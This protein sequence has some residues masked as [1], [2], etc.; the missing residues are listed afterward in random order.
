M[1][2]VATPLARA[3]PHVQPAISIG[4]ATSSGTLLLTYLFVRWDGVTA[5]D[6]GIAP[7]RRSVIRLVAGFTIGLVLVAINTLAM[8]S[9]GHVTWVR[10]PA[11]SHSDAAMTLVAFVLLASREELAFHGYPL[12]RLECSFGLGVAQAVVALVFALEHVAG[13]AGWVNAFLGSGIGALLFGMAAIASRGLA[14]PIGLHAAWNVGDW[15]RGGKDSSGLWRPIVEQEYASSVGM[16]GMGS[17][18][19]VFLMTTFGLWMW[20]R[21]FGRSGDAIG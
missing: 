7:D 20:H 19:A 8:W 12:R 11:P 18:I 17:Y 2:I 14:M 6:V 1:L 16:A 15:I 4:L 10:A 5:Q 13:G 3:I 21:T 9:T